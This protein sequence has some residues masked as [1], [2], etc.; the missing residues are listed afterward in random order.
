MAYDVIVVGGGPAGLMAA[1]AAGLGGARVLL[2][3]K[4]DKL[5][6][7]LAISGGGRCNVTNNKPIDELIRHIPGNGRFL[8]RALSTFGPR[9]IIRFFEELGVRLKEEDNGRMF[10][11][12]DRA[13]ETAWPARSPRRRSRTPSRPSCPSVWRRS[14]WS[15]R[16]SP[17]T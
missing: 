14:S 9:E 15:A 12:S 5:G 11:V 6:R 2:L 10:P 1:A 16:R 17:A 7:K 13:K 8:Y 4:K 3:E